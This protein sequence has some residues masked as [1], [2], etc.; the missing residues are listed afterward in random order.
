MDIIINSL[1]GGFMM[2]YRVLNIRTGKSWQGEAEN[3]KAAYTHIDIEP[4]DTT[5]LKY[6][7][8]FSVKEWRKQK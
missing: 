4:G 2:E 3:A 1:I 5:T 7:R 8:L 6:G